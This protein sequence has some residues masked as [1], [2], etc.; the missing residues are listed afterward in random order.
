MTAPEVGRTDHG[1]VRVDYGATGIITAEHVQREMALRDALGGH[2]HATLVL[3]PG[4]WRVDVGAAALFSGR[5]MASRTM[6]CAIV[7]ESSLGN[8]AVRV[9]ELYHRPPYPFAVF[10]RE[11][12]AVDWLLPHLR[13]RA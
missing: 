11:D 3:M 1:I 7:V 12:D 2:P 5:E 4:A 6:A 9:F 10:G 8:L 13:R